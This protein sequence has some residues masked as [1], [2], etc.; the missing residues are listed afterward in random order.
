MPLLLKKQNLQHDSMGKKRTALTLGDLGRH[1]INEAITASAQMELNQR[2]LWNY[3]IRK[4]TELVNETG[5]GA[6]SYLGLEQLSYSMDL[7]PYRPVWWRRLL[8]LKSKFP[9]GK[10]YLLK[11]I[12]ENKAH[13]HFTVTVSK[14][15]PMVYEAKYATNPPTE[16]KPDE[17]H[18]IGIPK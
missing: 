1:L 12:K 9:V 10:T 15:S 13:I 7:I 5:M 11:K 17:T 8:G 16:I 18:V 4:N 14:K 3:L 2:H 6:A